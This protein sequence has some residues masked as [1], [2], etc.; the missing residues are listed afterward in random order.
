M[1][2]DEPKPDKGRKNRMAPVP[3]ASAQRKKG[4]KEAPDQESKRERRAPRKERESY[5]RLRL[6]VEGG[7]MS[8]VGIREVEG[9]LVQPDLIH[10]G[11]IYEV[12]VGDRRISVGSIPDAG[13]E[14]SFPDPRE[15]ERGHYVTEVP[16]YEVSVRVPTAE[17]SRSAIGR[18]EVAL[19]RA[20]ELTDQPI[21]QPRISDQFSREL[22]EVARLKG[23]RG[24]DLPPSLRKDLDRILS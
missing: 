6:R 1:M 3:R 18:L 13:V 10:G 11:L 24:D 7:E 23:L 14:R 15:P 22:R 21:G 16:T 9:P 12:S 2:S 5:V 20:K 17:L 19:Y 4:R 8:V